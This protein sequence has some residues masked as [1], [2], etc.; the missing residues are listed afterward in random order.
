MAQVLREAKAAGRSRLLTMRVNLPRWPAILRLLSRDGPA[1]SAACSVQ[2][3]D[4]RSPLASP[5]PPP[6]RCTFRLGGQPSG[7]S[8]LGAAR[9]H[10]RVHTAVDTITA[11]TPAPSQRPDH[12]LDRACPAPPVPGR[13]GRRRAACVRSPFRQV[14]DE[15]RG[16]GHSWHSRTR[17][18]ALATE[19]AGA[20]GDAG[21]WRNR[22]TGAMIGGKGAACASW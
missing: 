2:L 16:S 4:V 20:A 6:P 12:A 17:E 22:G 15:A 13:P 10:C 7:L 9:C 19:E 11:A 18:G 1:K 5:L 8:I 14:L 21:A 3:T